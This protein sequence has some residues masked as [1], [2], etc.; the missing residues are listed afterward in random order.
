MQQKAWTRKLW[1]S[2]T[3]MGVAAPPTPPHEPRRGPTG[4]RATRHAY[5]AAI[6]DPRVLAL[7]GHS[8][9]S[10]KPAMATA[11][12]RMQPHTPRQQQQQRVRRRVP[13]R[14]STAPARGAEREELERQKSL[15]SKKKSAKLRWR[16]TIRTAML[17][18]SGF[19]AP[20]LGAE[21]PASTSTLTGECIHDALRSSQCTVQRRAT[22]LH[23][24]A[25]RGC[26]AS[27]LRHGLSRRLTRYASCAGACRADERSKR[28][29][30]SGLACD[31][32][33]ATVR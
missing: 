6:A 29:L 26:Q 32:L 5:N 22:H 20:G 28:R 27:V 1:Q 8:T 15:S 11:G 25:S 30:T 14:P 17:A 23:S 12:T 33:L 21:A 7:L 24:R 3:A 19:V 2:A 4:G 9:D 10:E 18:K 16:G 13:R 31:C